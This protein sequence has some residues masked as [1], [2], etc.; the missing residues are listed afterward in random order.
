MTTAEVVGFFNFFFC[1]SINSSFQI[2]A[3]Y[4][5]IREHE[6]VRVKPTSV[7]HHLLI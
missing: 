4:L 3:D 2:S 7:F 1:E 5:L 6:K